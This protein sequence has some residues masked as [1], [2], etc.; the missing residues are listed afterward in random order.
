MACF[1][2]FGPPTQSHTAE[3]LA[4]HTTTESLCFQRSRSYDVSDQSTMLVHVS[5]QSTMLVPAV[6]P[7]CIANC[8]CW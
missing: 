7:V 6:P 3:Q 2:D 5:D 1:I 8:N 4:V